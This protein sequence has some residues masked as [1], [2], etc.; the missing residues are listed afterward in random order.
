MYSC[1]LITEPDSADV[2]EVV[3]INGTVLDSLS[4]S[5]LA[6]VAINIAYADTNVGPVF[7]DSSGNFSTT[8]RITDNTDITVNVLLEGYVERNESE[9]II[10]GRS[11]VDLDVIYLLSTDAQ[12]IT[13]SGVVRDSLT[14]DLLEGVE[15]NLATE[16]STIGKVYTSS[17]GKYSFSILSVSNFDVYITTS[18]SDYI[19]KTDT[20]TVKVGQE[21]LTVS[22]I[23]IVPAVT[24]TIVVH[25]KVLNSL[26]YTPIENGV[27][28]F[29]TEGREL[30]TKLTNSNGEYFFEV[31]T[32][33]NFTIDVTAS[34]EGFTQVSNSAS[35]ALGRDSIKI[36]NMLMF[37]AS[38]EAVAVSGSVLDSVSFS[39]LE[40]AEIL[41]YSN[42]QVIT[43]TATSS[44]G[45]F[46]FGLTVDTDFDVTITTNLNGYNGKSR[47]VSITK[48]KSTV[49]LPEFYLLPDEAK[50]FYISGNVSDS[51]DLNSLENVRI[52]LNINNETYATTFS[53]SSGSYSLDIISVPELVYNLSASKD[54]YIDNNIIIE[55]P[56]TGSSLAVPDI[57]LL[58][59]NAKT[60]NVFGV[61]NDS[62][63]LDPL[64]KVDITIESNG[65]DIGSAVTDANGEY[66][67]DILTASDKKITV[68]AKFS[69]YLSKTTT[70][71]IPLGNTSFNI[72][73]FDL[74]P[75]N[76]ELI[77]I[78]GQIIDGDKYEPLEDA[79]VT[80]VRNEKTVGTTFTDSDGF[81]THSFFT[82]SSF[83][84]TIGAELEGYESNSTTASISLGRETIEIPDILLTPTDPGDVE[85]VEPA[86]I[87]LYSQSVSSVGVKE[88]GAIETAQIEFEVQ[89]SS[90]V[91]LDYD[92]QSIVYF[93]IQN[94]PGGGEYLY[95]DS[96]LTNTEGHATVSFSSGTVAGTAQ[97]IAYIPFNGNI[98]KS[99]PVLIAVQGGFPDKDH[100]T[101]TPDVHNIPGLL[102]DNFEDV[103]TVIVG[104][105]YSNP[106]RE[107]TSVYFNTTGGVIGAETQTDE[108][109][110]GS[111]T[112]RTGNPHP[113]HPIRGFGHVDVVAHTINE[114][115]E[116][117]RDTTFVLFS[118][119]PVISNVDPITFNIENG[120]SQHVN[121]TVTDSYG[122]PVAASSNFSVSA[123]IGSATLSGDVDFEHGDYLY[124]GGSATEFSF[125]I[126][127]PDDSETDPAQ[128]VTIT[129]EV[130]VFGFKASYNISGM[131]D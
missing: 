87:Y 69:G 71:T 73:D 101:V 38:S 90:G 70:V 109:G 131:I 47:I 77:T 51:L 83:S 2:G 40:N 78:K 85:S 125:T 6:S 61:V 18:Y 53:N 79:I 66:S 86:S 88:S 15:L 107:G 99:R 44:S 33:T 103:I 119:K 126:F 115:S 19:T 64:E 62:I 72:P 117:I 20:A 67:I 43:S 30:G 14:L 12:T 121:Y 34:L 80:F 55:M 21:T 31:L 52:D 54:N 118:G 5:P 7:T 29:T 84:I 114:N 93:E 74:V 123:T 110:V 36:P 111:V 3:A 41:V 100:F 4:L 91:A 104:D 120:G 124:P 57:F 24:E 128:S 127:D 95:P 108:N 56:F 129:I 26:T 60:V 63:S 17:E 112:L 25:G 22:D 49:L 81:Y 13:I 94:G 58:S 11:S 116:D 105:K 92:H 39:P 8:V 45:S 75:E 130:D 59:E 76:A 23:L 50:S 102:F 68:T 89:D 113:T 37:P 9:K 82:A 28:N 97:I 42:N 46:N 27:M 10:L 122:N 48:D 106:V 35:I 96:I 16:D 32:A 1:K 65:K 98:I